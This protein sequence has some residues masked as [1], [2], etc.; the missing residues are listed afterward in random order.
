MG[1]ANKKAKNTKKSG[2]ELHNEPTCVGTDNFG[3]DQTRRQAQAWFYFKIEH[4]RARLALL[5]ELFSKFSHF[6]VCVNDKAPHKRNN[7]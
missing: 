7:G 2:I 3:E 6:A 1:S 4:Q 5:F